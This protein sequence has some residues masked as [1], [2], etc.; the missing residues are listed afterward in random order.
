M[1]KQKILVCLLVLGGWACEG[2]TG[3][4]DPSVEQSKADLLNDPIS[5]PRKI[6]GTS[7]SDVYILDWNNDLWHYT[8]TNTFTR[9]LISAGVNNSPVVNFQVV[10]AGPGVLVQTADYNLWYYNSGRPNYPNP[11]WVDGSVGQFQVHPGTDTSVIMVLSAASDHSL[12][13]EQ[14][15]MYNRQRIDIGVTSFQDPVTGNPNPLV[16]ALHGNTLNAVSYVLGGGYTPSPLLT[17]VVDFEVTSAGSG[18]MATCDIIY[19]K[20]ASNNLWQHPC[21]GGYADVKVDGNVQQFK[22]WASGDIYVVGTNGNLWR[23]TEIVQHGKGSM[24]RNQVDGNV[25]Y[26]SPWGWDSSSSIVWVV[27]SA[28]GNVWREVGNYHNRSLLGNILTM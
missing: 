9:T 2:G 13:R 17:R 15:D 10:G 3:V 6:Q 19:W 20:D 16:F 27:S 8:G 28:D 25:S 24:T 18:S 22:A 11:Y 26:Y 4:G 21:G 23:E 14:W 5:V 12:W 1:R 7:N